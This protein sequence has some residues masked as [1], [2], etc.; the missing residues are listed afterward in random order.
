MGQGQSSDYQG[1]PT[2]AGQ[3]KTD[4]YELLGVERTASE[5]EIRKAYRRKALELHP[6][7]NYNNVENATKLFAEIQSAYEVLSDPQERAWYDSHRDILLRGGQE[8]GPAAD[9]YSYNIR[10]TTAEEVLGFMMKFSGR[11]EFSDS[12]SGF[13]GGLWDF[14]NNLAKEEEIACQWE[15]A[16]PVEYP[17]FGHK[18]DD[19]EE[20]V[21][22]FYGAWNGFATRKSYSW[23]DQY[24]LSEAPDRRIRRLMEKEN[25]KLREEAVREYN[26][27]VR[28]LIAFVRKRDPRFQ[29]NK[30]SEAER[31]TILR[32]AAAAQKARSRA[33][34]QAQMAELDRVAVPDWAKSK[35]VDDHEG[36][37]SS[38]EDS[39]EHEFDCVVCDKTFKSEAQY[40]V[41]EK[42]KKHIKMLKQLK[43]EMR[44]EGHDLAL[45]D[46]ARLNE[47]T[48]EDKSE[49]T[50][51]NNGKIDTGT[52][53]AD[54]DGG[55]D[56]GEQKPP[57]ENLIISN[58]HPGAHQT[59]S[60]SATEEEDDADYAPRSVV[61]DRLDNEAPD[62]L[63]SRLKATGLDDTPETSGTED[64]SQPKLGKAK[65]KRAKKAS[66]KEGGKSLG[67][68][69]ADFKCAVCQAGFPS[70]TRLF[71]HI[72]DKN[73][74]API[75]Q[76]K[77]KAGKGKRK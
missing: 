25:K 54:G 4:Y 12:P 66:Q 55:S 10:M 15:D 74:A 68:N 13:Y 19:Y 47:Q 42:S 28:S 71:T 17:E 56:D 52:N 24:R 53:R 3:T 31:Q 27:A 43:K 20:V 9:E 6:D 7:R 50:E 38:E 59:P 72:K 51:N 75:A 58:G 57:E 67:V 73:H 16:E 41:H 77:G 21:R 70:K 61:E 35:P 48:P 26:D 69:D 11:M 45:D 37:F 22:P 40:Q 34:R 39:E 5:D 49:D 64:P 44:N 32:D 18:D 65:L 1:S 62:D 29:E 76:M 2:D 14:F 8:G 36:G 46:P 33:A 23:K 30:K 63:P 60:D